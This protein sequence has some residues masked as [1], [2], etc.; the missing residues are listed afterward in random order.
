M[1]A[2]H[3]Q[4]VS[5]FGRSG[6]ARGWISQCVEQ[7]IVQFLVPLFGRYELYADVQ[8]NEPLIRYCFA[9]GQDATAFHAAF[10]DAAV[11]SSFKKAG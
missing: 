8:G 1:A 6:A 2:G 7:Q 11:K 4:P 10:A 9:Q 5:P 3:R